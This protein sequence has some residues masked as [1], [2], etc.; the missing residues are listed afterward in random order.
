MESN[1]KLRG[2]L[3]QGIYLQLRNGIGDW[4]IDIDS[5][6]VVVFSSDG[7][8]WSPHS[9]PSKSKAVKGLWARDLV[10]QMEIDVQQIW[11]AWSAMNDMVV[12]DFLS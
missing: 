11:L 3:A 6:C 10:N 5:G 7:E 1:S 4:F 12:P 8:L 2:V 9:A